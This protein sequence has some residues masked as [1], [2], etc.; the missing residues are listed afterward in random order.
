MQSP[1]G[2]VNVATFGSFLFDNSDLA[3]RPASPSHSNM[4]LDLG[5][6]IPYSL[7]ITIESR[8]KLNQ[9]SRHR[10]FCRNDCAN[11]GEQ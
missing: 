8:G 11:I 2:G 4:V 5:F 6:G 3:L 9:N 1:C 10:I 7:T